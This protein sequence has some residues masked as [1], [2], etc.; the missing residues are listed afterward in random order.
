[1]NA[2]EAEAYAVQVRYPTDWLPIFSDEQLESFGR[3]YEHERLSARGVRFLKFCR[4]PRLFGYYHSANLGA[5][6]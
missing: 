6:A 4:A 2:T 1:M 5:T 3:F